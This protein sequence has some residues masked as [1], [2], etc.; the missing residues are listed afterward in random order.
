[1]ND[2]PLH[3]LHQKLKH[4]HADTDADA[5]GIAIALHVLRTGELK[6]V[7]YSEGDMQAIHNVNW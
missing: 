7:N 4:F 2:K 1:M 3:Y 5:G 6:R